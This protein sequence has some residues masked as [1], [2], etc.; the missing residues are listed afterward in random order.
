[1]KINGKEILGCGIIETALEGLTAKEYCIC[2]TY[3]KDRKNGKGFDIRR[4]T[5]PEIVRRNNDLALALPE[6][7]GENM[8]EGLA[9]ATCEKFSAKYAVPMLAIERKRL[10]EL[11]AI[12]AAKKAE[13]TA[14]GE[15]DSE[16][17]SGAAAKEKRPAKTAAEKI[18]DIVAKIKDTSKLFKF[19]QLFPAMEAIDEKLAN[20]IAEV[21]RRAYIPEAG[22]SEAATAK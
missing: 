21:I 19:E 17:E 22:K 18:V 6:F 3:K 8:G 13:K 9:L 4:T 20:E 15:D 2:V 14:A 5:L 10:D 12:A 16:N 1:M 11:K 7:I